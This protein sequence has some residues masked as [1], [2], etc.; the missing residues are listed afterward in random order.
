MKQRL[1]ARDIGA[2]GRHELVQRVLERLGQFLLGVR[3]NGQVVPC[4]RARERQRRRPASGVVFLVGAV[5]VDLRAH[6]LQE[7]LEMEHCVRLHDLPCV[8]ARS[9][10]TT[11]QR[12]DSSGGPWGRTAPLVPSAIAVWSVGIL[13]HARRVIESRAAA[14]CP[15]IRW[16]P[17]RRPRSVPRLR[18]RSRRVR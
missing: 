10:S 11:S 2:L 3:E 8:C 6:F 5:R 14:P 12:R 17:P 1:D 7:L 16:S 4:H 18:T 15:C 9:E 13:D